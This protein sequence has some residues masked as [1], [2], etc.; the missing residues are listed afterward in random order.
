MGPNERSFGFWIAIAGLGVL[1]V[2]ALVAVLRAPTVG[3]A[4]AVI[5]AAGSVVGTVVGAFFGV[6]AGA[7]SGNARADQSDAARQQAEEARRSAESVRDQM[8]GGLVRIAATAAP[9]SET[10]AAVRELLDLAA[11]HKAPTSPGSS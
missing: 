10:G 9:G 4:S 6:H 1:L 11:S 8:T 3:D 2:I 5:T 7:A